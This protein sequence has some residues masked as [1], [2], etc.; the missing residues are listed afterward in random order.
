MF[1]SYPVIGFF[2]ALQLIDLLGIFQLPTNSLSDYLLWYRACGI[3]ERVQGN[4]IFTATVLS[5]KR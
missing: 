1:N 2:I 5:F 4:L 3:F